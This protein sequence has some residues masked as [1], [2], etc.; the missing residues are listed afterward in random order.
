MCSP[1]SNPDFWSQFFCCGSPAEESFM[2]GPEIDALYDVVSDE[3][4]VD[5]I[6]DGS[7]TGA[8][9]DTSDTSA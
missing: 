7:D 2:T 4:I 6:E 3:H 9:Q 1:C 5:L 8:V